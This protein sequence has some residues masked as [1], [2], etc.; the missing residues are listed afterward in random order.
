MDAEIKIL[1]RLRRKLV[2]RHTGLETRLA[3]ADQ[4]RNCILAGELQAR[5]HELAWA[6]HDLDWLVDDLKERKK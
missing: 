4:Q 3:E 1:K 2:A 6:I 5:Q